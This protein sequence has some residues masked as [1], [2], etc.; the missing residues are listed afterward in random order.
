MNLDDLDLFKKIDVEDM[1]S[2]ILTLPQQVQEAWQLGQHLSP[3]DENGYRQIIIAGMGGSAIG[4]DMLAAYAAPVCRLPIHVHR[5][6]D[7]PAWARGKETLVILSSHSGDTEETISSYQSAIANGCSTLAIT[8]GGRIGQI[9]EEHGALQWNFIHAGQPRSAV[10]FNFML[11][12]AFLCRKGL[13]PDAGKD[14][15]AAVDLMNAQAKS[16]APESPVAGNPAKRMAGQLINR[17]VTVV[18]AGYLAPIARRWKGQINEIAK[19]WAQ[20]E[21]LPEIDHNTLAGIVNPECQLQQMM[22]LFLQSSCDHP[23]NRLR[24]DLTRQAFMLEGLNTDFIK[25]AG[26]SPMEQIW[27]T[28]Q[29]GDFLAY[30]LA[31][32]YQIDPTPIPAIQGFKQQM[33]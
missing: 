4:A 20:F 24:M 8:R 23:R 25:A 5:D 32:A 26:E 27:S 3:G 21:F 29:F 30:Y 16:L 19:A 10:G 13:L 28:L 18:G 6:Y 9:A 2:H 31:M 12:L 1:L 14:V 15:A 7:L 33:K 11:P 17:W 22:T